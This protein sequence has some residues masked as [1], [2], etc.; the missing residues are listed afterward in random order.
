ME[1]TSKPAPRLALFDF[2]GTLTRSDTMFA[3]LSFVRGRSNLWLGMLWLSKTLLL[4]K[5]GRISAEEGK[6]K[7]LNY[8]IGGMSE[9]ELKKLAQ[10]FCMEQLP[11]L[12][13]DEALER[14]HFHR[15]KGHIVYVVTAS[16]DLWVA[17]WLDEQRLPGLCTQIQWEDGA[18]KGNFATPNC[19]GPEKARRIQAALDLT[20][21]EH[22][23]AYG[24][25]KG[26]REMLEL[27]TKRFYQRFY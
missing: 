13:R 10:A 6:K 26:D 14:L 8:F 12:F 20:K 16:L 22:I 5:L 15:S 4:T 3:F 7:L 23:F 18:F 17:P 27:A 21:F 19:N 25:S 9:V 1:D 24:D 11:E 2:D